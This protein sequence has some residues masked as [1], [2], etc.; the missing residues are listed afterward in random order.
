MKDRFICNYA[1]LRFRPYLETG[2]F[3][4]LGVVLF[5]GSVGFFG[6]RIETRQQ[7]R[8]SEFFPEL[9]VA[10]FRLARARFRKEVLRVKELLVAPESTLKAEERLGVFC[11]LVRPRESVFRFTEVSTAMA[12]DLEAKLEELFQRYVRRRIGLSART[13]QSSMR[14]P[15]L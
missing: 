10:Q 14:T 1:V 2:E 3:I 7:R 13:P 15:D 5:A 12:D 9:D 4:N 11:E 6:F 8:V